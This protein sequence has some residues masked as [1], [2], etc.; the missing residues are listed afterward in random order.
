MVLKA[1]RVAQP[2]WSGLGRRAIFSFSPPILAGMMLTEMLFER[3]L[4]VMLPGVWL[5]LYGVAV[6]GA[7]AFSVRVVPILGLA[8]MLVSFIAFFFADHTAPVLG[9]LRISDLA[10]LGGFGGLH[11]IFGLIIALRHGG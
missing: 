10:L 11:I 5:L 3:K 9:P 8:F 2:V 6:C 4:Q 7:G 1:R